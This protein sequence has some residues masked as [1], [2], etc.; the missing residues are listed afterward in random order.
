MRWPVEQMRRLFVAAEI[1][2]LSAFVSSA[3]ATDATWN[4]SG[5]DWTNSANWSPQSPG[6]DDVAQ[7]AQ[8]QSGPA[9]NPVLNSTTT[10]QQLILGG[11]PPA[12]WS[13]TGTGSLSTG[14]NGSFVS[15]PEGVTGIITRAGTGDFTFN[16]GDGTDPSLNLSGIGAPVGGLITISSDSTIT[17]TGNTIA[18]NTNENT[19]LGN[20]TTSGPLFIRGGT[21]VLDNSAGNPSSQRLTT[22]GGI[23]FIGGNSTL[24]LLGSPS[25]SAFTGM[26]GGLSAGTGDGYLQLVS[27]GGSLSADFST[28][29]RSVPAGF[30]YVE[31]V[32]SG[33]VGNAGDPTVTANNAPNVRQGVMSTSSSA[34]I[35]WAMVTNQANS[36]SAITGR[37]ATYSSGIV[38]A[39]TTAFTGDFSSAASGSNILFD[40]T[41][42]GTVNQATSTNQLAT[43][44]FEPAVA[45]VTYNV[46]DG[47]QI[48][49]Y[50]VAL[51][52]SNSM[53]VT[54][55][56]LIDTSTDAGTRSVIVLDP[57]ASL[58]TSSDLGN[59]QGISYNSAVDIG[60][61]GFVVLTGA[62]NQVSF[63]QTQ[64]INLNGGVLRV[65]TA[66]FNPS[67]A[68][69]CFRGGVLEYD[70]SGGSASFNL[71]IGAGADQVNWGSTSQASAGENNTTNCG[72]GGFSAYSGP[73][74][75]NGNTLT[76][77][78]GGSAAQI[79]WD[80]PG[81]VAGLY[82]L[83]FGSA[84]SNSTVIF[85]NPIDLDYSAASTPATGAGTYETR[86]IN[87]T[88]GV[89]NPADKTIMAGTIS[90]SAGFDL[91][92]TGTGVLELDAANNYAGGTTVAGG[93]L[94]AATLNAVPADSGVNVTSGKLLLDSSIGT[95]TLSSLAVSGS[96]QVD[97][98]N[99]TVLIDYGSN[100]SPIGTIKSY[101]QTGFNG[102]AWNGSGIVSSSVAA[103]NASQNMSYAVGYADGADGVVDGL[104]S[105]EVEIT[106]TLVGDADLNGTV[107]FHDLQ[108]LLGDFGQPGF[109]DQGNF[110]FHSTVDFNDLQLLL[111]NF[112]GSAK[113]SD[114]ETQGIENLVG[115]FG[116]TAIANSN[117]VGFTLVS[118]PEPA[119]TWI[120][121]SILSVATLRR[122]QKQNFRTNIVSF[123]PPKRSFS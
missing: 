47:N 77:N 83:K 55:G 96:G 121:I 39:S 8:S 70:V 119:G 99:N 31:N 107:N 81:F 16:L 15:D 111:G 74:N 43:V 10:I 21:L 109:W 84:D 112:G 17:L 122:R 73:G 3:R 89:G 76:V 7:F 1:A 58:Y 65:T 37:W 115:Q 42:A 75:G 110:N 34:T 23:D 67:N 40:P 80:D 2:A 51:S 53:T 45:G 103:L 44:L 49:T 64:N 88:K 79:N 14:V 29:G 41:L 32:G 98:T 25:G 54:G 63:S 35:P 52:G 116:Y 91:V 71:A 13:L 50:G 24:E 38:A 5:T 27:A 11:G 62:S 120:S 94:E 97:V 28:I 117:G 72:S 113:L 123:N 30:L 69:V 33:F 118:V 101:V 92:K 82:A 60:G 20:G 18:E 46:G 22:A 102:G 6:P 85:E 66:N 12:G 19:N 56:S 114:S 9:I 59:S 104:S 57:R 106:P 78:L 61:Q 68:D 105:G 90:G 108:L 87:V 93:V 86:E 4:N 100:A 36:S 95:Q 26:T 48:D